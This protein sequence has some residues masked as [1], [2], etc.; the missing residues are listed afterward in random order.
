MGVNPTATTG[1]GL[2]WVRLPEK[3]G[4]VPD[5]KPVVVVERRASSCSRVRSWT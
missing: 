2:A 5:A 3:F 1:T 4:Q